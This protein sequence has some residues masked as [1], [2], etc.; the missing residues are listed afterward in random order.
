MKTKLI[1]IISIIIGIS[2]FFSAIYF[3]NTVTEVY[4]VDQATRHYVMINASCNNIE[5]KPDGQCFVNAFEN[6]ESATVKQMSHSVEGDPIFHYVRIMPEDSCNIHFKM[7]VSLDKWKGI[8]SPD[9]IEEICT[10]VTL[11]ENNLHFVCGDGERRISL[12]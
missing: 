9:I 8:A 6:C 2:I 10:D 4:S 5:G 12:R 1:V 3:L 7:D 11:D